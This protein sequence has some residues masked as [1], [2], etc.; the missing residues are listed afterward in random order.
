MK[1]LVVFLAG[2]MIGVALAAA[3][4]W[5][6]PLSGEPRHA[7]VLMHGVSADFHAS[8][9]A[10][11]LPMLTH[12]GARRLVMRPESVPELWEST[13]EPLDAGML[14]LR[15]AD[16]Q[17]VGTASRIAA[18]A[19]DTD[20]LQR[21]ILVDS[22][23]IISL[24]GVGMAFAVQRENVWPMLREIALPAWFRRE[25]WQGEMRFTPAAG[26]RE[27]RAGRLLGIA[28]VLAGLDGQMVG[29]YRLRA[30]DPAIGPTVL[31][32]HGVLSVPQPEA[33]DSVS[34][35]R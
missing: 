8:L 4:L 33:P 21:G 16:G 2:L 1:S 27:D 19:R 11:D 20:L 24:D 22:S 12:S 15:D 13:I 14:L 25:P 34:A 6:N 3:I 30:F 35:A 28:G 7:P 17:V 32:W 18:A 26:P 29:N 31:E 5:F 23:W 10:E 9:R